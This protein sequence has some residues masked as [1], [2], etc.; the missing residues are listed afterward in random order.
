M[1]N[2]TISLLRYLTVDNHVYGYDL[3]K[4]TA[5]ILRQPTTDLSSILQNQDEIN[6]IGL[7]YFQQPK[8]SNKRRGG[9]TKADNRAQSALYLAAADDAG[10]VRVMDTGSSSSQI[11]H[12]DP[13]GVVLVP[14]CAFRPGGKG[15]ELVSGGTDCKI[16]LWDVSKPRYVW[17][18]FWKVVLA[19]VAHGH[20][21]GA[22]SLHLR[23]LLLRIL[24]KVANRKCAIHHMCIP[25]H[26][27]RVEGS[28]RP[29]LGTGIAMSS[30]YKIGR[31]YK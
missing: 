5:P 10:T 30:P 8:G 22:Q 6:Q 3:R 25:W 7:S 18:Q 31:S 28:W 12:H 1:P 4:A 20:I 15:L 2:L 13:S 19:N 29:D 11:L 24:R 17:G 27:V 26:G 23:S 14:S 9:K 16:H 21:V